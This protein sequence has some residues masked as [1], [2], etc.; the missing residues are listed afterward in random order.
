MPKRGRHWNVNRSWRTIRKMLKLKMRMFHR[1]VEIPVCSFCCRRYT[2]KWKIKI[3][4]SSWWI[5]VRPRL[6]SNQELNLRIWSTFQKIESIKGI[7]MAAL[8]NIQNWNLSSIN[9]KNNNF[10]TIFFCHFLGFHFSGFLLL[11]CHRYF[12]RVI[13]SYGKN[14]EKWISLC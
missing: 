4:H 5:V 9:Q 11:C 10:S 8:S 14:A 7:F 3:K 1:L 12:R 13:K 2:N 6:I